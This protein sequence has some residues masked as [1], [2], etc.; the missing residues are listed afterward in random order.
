MPN[1]RLMVAANFLYIYYV[2]KR[3]SDDESAL[4]FVV[5]VVVQTSFSP[6]IPQRIPSNSKR[7]ETTL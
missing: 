3:K 2:H 7:F 1:G 4:V 6:W 5:V